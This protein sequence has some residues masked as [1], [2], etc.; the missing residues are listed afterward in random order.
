M[1]LPSPSIT[2]AVRSMT[3][4]ISNMSSLAGETTQRMA[5]G[6]NLASAMPIQRSTPCRISALKATV[7]QLR[8]GRPG[9]HLVP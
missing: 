5:V 7:D 3:G 6:P 4:S 8:I 1:V 2:E 9:V